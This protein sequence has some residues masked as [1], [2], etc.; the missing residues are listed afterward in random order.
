MNNIL[1]HHTKNTL[2]LIL[3]LLTLL[4]CAQGLCIGSF[5]DEPTEQ[6][7]NTALNSEITNMDLSGYVGENLIGNVKN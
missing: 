2:C 6:K 5:A 7:E 1:L 3:S 4:P